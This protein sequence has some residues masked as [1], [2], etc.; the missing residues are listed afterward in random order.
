MIS[1]ESTFQTFVTL[2]SQNRQSSILARLRQSKKN[3]PQDSL[4]R[5]ADGQKH[6]GKGQD[7]EWYAAQQDN[8]AR[9]ERQRLQPSLHLLEAGFG[10]I[11]ERVE[12]HKST[13]T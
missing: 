6:L 3:G 2:N 7:I 12:C 11:L 4:G 10:G 8:D 5:D 1:L 13:V 9:P